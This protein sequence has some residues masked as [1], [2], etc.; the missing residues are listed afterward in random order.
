MDPFQ[1]IS[2][3]LFSQS[4]TKRNSSGLSTVVLQHSGKLKEAK[5]NLH[6]AKREAALMRKEVDIK[7]ELSLLKIKQELD[8]AESKLLTVKKAMN[9]SS[10]SASIDSAKRDQIHHTSPSVVNSDRSSKVT[11][12]TLEYV[13]DQIQHTPVMNNPVLHT[14]EPHVSNRSSCGTYEPP[15]VNHL[16]SDPY[17]PHMSDCPSS[18]TYRLP[19]INNSSL[20]TFEPRQFN[21]LSSGTYE[22]PV[23]NV[24]TSDTYDPLKSDCPSSHTYGLPVMNDSVTSVKHSSPSQD[25]PLPCAYDPPIAN[26]TSPSVHTFPNP[27]AK[28]FTPAS[29]KINVE[30][31]ELAKFMVKKD[32][33]TSRLTV[34][35][36]QPAHYAY[37]KASFQNIMTELDAT[38]L[39]HLDLLV[40][41]LGPNSKHQAM[42][43]RSANPSDLPK[44][45]KLIWERL[46]DRFGCPE[47]IEA[48]LRQRIKVFPKLNDSHRVELYELSDLVAEIESVKA[49]PCFQNLFAYFD[50]SAG[51]NKK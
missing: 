19:V 38:P 8:V 44:A 25:S 36:D 22:P 12:R 42:N 46:E 41:S 16:P 24:L 21:R 31:Q 40:K 11:Q 47:M 43:I 5:I 49:N 1:K 28:E 3:S 7:A 29:R 30:C 37:W 45:V 23:I 2:G 34:F 26:H 48:A 14:C 33:L 9:F 6:Y 32:L 4:S 27:C 51:V 15:V 17:D 50:S 18:G 13:N 10:T 20:P 35:D 39:E